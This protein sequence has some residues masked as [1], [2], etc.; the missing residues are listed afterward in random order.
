M[1]PITHGLL[2]ATTA[3]LGFVQKLG[4]G[5]A[6]MAAVAAMLP[7]MDIFVA[8][9]MRVM[10]LTVD[11]FDGMKYHR[12]LSHSLLAAPVLALVV[13]IVWYL[14]SRKMFLGKYLCC[15]LG[16]FCHPL[17]DWCT[18]YGTQLLSPLSNHRFAINAVPIVD[19]I[20]TPLLATTLLAAWAIRKFGRRRGWNGLQV[21]WIGMILSVAYLGTGRLMHEVAMRRGI[22]AYDA[23]RASTADNSPPGKLKVQAYPS[24]GTIF[25]WRIVAQ[26]DA[27]WYVGRTHTLFDRPVTLTHHQDDS[28]RFVDAAKQ[29]ERVAMFDW[30]AS[31]QLRAISKDVAGTPVVELHDMRYAMDPADGESLWYAQVAFCHDGSIESVRRIHNGRY[32]GSFN[33]IAAMCW[34]DLFRP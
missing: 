33:R 14:F 10:G 31:G 13:S 4:R 7:D 28:D 9:A 21:A 3:H 17:L 6:T 32:D 11:S 15:L 1:D 19:I 26:D 23:A 2:G 22:T 8:P 16:A 5:A 27:G 12:G 29:N 25:V 20:Y 18:S 34:R 30:F 24:L